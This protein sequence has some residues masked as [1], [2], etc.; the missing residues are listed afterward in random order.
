MYWTIQGKS[1]HQETYNYTNS[2]AHTLHVWSTLVAFKTKFAQMTG[3][4]LHALEVELAM[5]GLNILR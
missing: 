4:D 2:N 1:I 3:N 5:N